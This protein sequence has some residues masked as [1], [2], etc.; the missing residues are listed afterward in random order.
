MHIACLRFVRFATVLAS[1]TVP[2]LVN[3]LATIRNVTG[4]VR[5]VCQRGLTG[6]CS[7]A[8][9]TRLAA[10]RVGMAI[11]HPLRASVAELRIKIERSVQ[12]S[13]YYTRENLHHNCSKTGSRLWQQWHTYGH[14]KGGSWTRRRTWGSHGKPN[15]VNVKEDC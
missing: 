2:V 11:L 4:A 12:I 8:D 6:G 5:N 1:V 9:C 3:G 15:G 10:I 14:S 13:G 7:C